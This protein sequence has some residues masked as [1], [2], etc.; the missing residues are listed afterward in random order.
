MHF[1]EKLMMDLNNLSATNFK[2]NALNYQNKW[3]SIIGTFY[4]IILGISVTLYPI[5]VALALIFLLLPVLY[6]NQTI[7]I[8]LPNKLLLSLF[9]LSITLMILWPRYLVLK[10]GGPDITPQRI[11]HGV[12]IGAW[13]VALISPTYRTE[14]M[15]T[16]KRYSTIVLM[17]SMLIVLRIFSSL[18]SAYPTISLYGAINEILVADLPFFI[19]LGLIREPRHVVKIAFAIL[20]AGIVVAGLGIFESRLQHTLFASLIPPGMSFSSEYIQQAISEKIRGGAYRIQSTFSHPLLLAE[21][22][23]FVFP[24]AVYFAFAGKDKLSKFTGILGLF[25][26]PVA[27]ILTGS[28]AGV[29][30]IIVIVLIISIFLV[31]RSLRQQTFGMA[32]L[33]TVILSSALISAVMI[34]ILMAGIIRSDYFSGRNIDEKQSSKARVTMIQNGLPLIAKQPFLGYG[35]NMAANELGFKGNGALTIDNYYL[36]LAL[37]SG[38]FAPILFCFIVAVVAYMGFSLGLSDLG[39]NGLLAGMLSTSLLGMMLIQLI[40]SIPHNLPFLYTTLS[41]ILLLKYTSEQSLPGQL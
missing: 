35:V 14:S 31:R 13:L 22:L 18:H 7:S 34:T 1:T 5:W 15:R 2:H 19:L 12:L 38:F 28:R 25:L 29:I 37:E 39:S 24:I 17:V 40:L 11:V 30:T 21:F 36:S 41:L 26:F 6:F 10:F 3:V 4:A 32:G 9:L 23:V 33:V 27:L 16:I 20:A 8:K